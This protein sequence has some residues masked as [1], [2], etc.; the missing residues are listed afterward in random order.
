MTERFFQ[1]TEVDPINWTVNIIPLP[2]EVA[3]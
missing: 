2:A 3:R 1:A